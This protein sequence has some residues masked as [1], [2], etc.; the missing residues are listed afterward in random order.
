[1]KLYNL[2]DPDDSEDELPET[3]D[4]ELDDT[5]PDPDI[6][7]FDDDVDEEADVSEVADE[8]DDL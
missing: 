4:A 2:P 8:D 7:D 1:M 3:M 5:T 6:D